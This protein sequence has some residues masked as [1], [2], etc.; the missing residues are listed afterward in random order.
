VLS[1][2][3]RRSGLGGKNRLI[4]ANTE[5][6]P[7]MPIVEL[8]EW[9][10]RTQNE[11]LSAFHDRFTKGK[12]FGHQHLFLY[13]IANRTLAQTRAFKQCVE[14]RNSLVATALLRL[15]LDTA[16]RL[17]ALFWVAD[18]NAFSKAVFNGSQIDRLKS[19]G[20]EQL[21]D[22][23][24]RD[25]LVTRYP[26]VETVYK[27]TSG[28]IHFSSHHI[29]EALEINDM[30]TASCTLKL[31]PNKPD[32]P[33]EEYTDCLAAF[34][35]IN[36]IIFVAVQDWFERFDVFVG[37]QVPTEPPLKFAP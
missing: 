21:K 7:H 11:L 13:G 5:T 36:M 32:Q 4:E 37:T 28:S 9:L 23:Y 12:E 35:H 17:Y 29:L 16:L 2:S 1:L 6:L 31:G 3:L 14:D 10:D 33:I 30:E 19:A 20:G 15:Q 22:K 26:W 25:K 27:Q 24:L 34:Q 8:F 18:P